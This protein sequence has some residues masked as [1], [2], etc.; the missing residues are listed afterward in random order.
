MKTEDELIED[1]VSRAKITISAGG[2]M[3]IDKGD[4]FSSEGYERSLK[5]SKLMKSDKYC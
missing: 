5:F 1:L 4:L 3:S 2:A